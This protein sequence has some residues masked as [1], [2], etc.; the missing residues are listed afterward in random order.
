MLIISGN[1]ALIISTKQLIASKFKVKDLG[2][3][4]FCLN[5][6]IIRN[7]VNKSICLT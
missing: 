7:P 6:Q 5:I 3:A 2:D 4:S 1:M